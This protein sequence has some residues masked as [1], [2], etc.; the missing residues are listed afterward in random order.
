[1]LTEDGAATGTSTW[2]GLTLGA[3][4]VL[5]CPGGVGGV[6]VV[7]AGVVDEVGAVWGVPEVSAGAELGGAPAWLV[8]LDAVV[9]SGEWSGVVGAGLSWW[10][11][12]LVG[13]GVVE[14]A[15]PDRSGGGVGVVVAGLSQSD[16]FF[17]HRRMLVGVG[18]GRDVQV[19]H[20]LY[21]DGEVGQ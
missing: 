5:H 10:A 2:G 11:V 9:V 12:G 14:F 21:G 7:G 18:V 19:D 8:G 20:R 3:E 16:P 6:E 13:G 4:E 15:A 17:D 1:M